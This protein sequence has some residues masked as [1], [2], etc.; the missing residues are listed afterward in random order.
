M[1]QLGAERHKERVGVRHAL[2][3][4]AIVSAVWRG[5]PIPPK[6][7]LLCALWGWIL[8]L[9]IINAIYFY[10]IN[11]LLS[12]NLQSPTITEDERFYFRTLPHPQHI[13]FKPNPVHLI[14]AYHPLLL[15]AI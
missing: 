4:M 6:H 3:V 8:G 2:E 10:F 15:R 9:F 1:A 7:F 13:L 14:A 11:I 5:S 12:I